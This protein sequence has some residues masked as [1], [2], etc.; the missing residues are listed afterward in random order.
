MI[1][2]MTCIQKTSSAT[3]ST[4]LNDHDNYNSYLQGID[5][6]YMYVLPHVVLWILTMHHQADENNQKDLSE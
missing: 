1:D 2:V 6:A 5:A 4:V 3:Y